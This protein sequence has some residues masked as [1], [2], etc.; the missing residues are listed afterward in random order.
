MNTMKDLPNILIVDDIDVNL[1]LLE[2]IIVN[3][4]TVNLIQALSGAEALEKIKG[5]ELA[6]AILD[7]K[8]PEMNG[9]ELALKIN[10]NRSGDNVPVIFLTAMSSNEH[11]EFIGYGSGAV[12]Y[13]YKPV[14]KHILLSKINVFID[15]YNHKQTIIKEAI[16]LQKTTDE[17]VWTNAALIK[18]EAKYRSYIESA[19]DGVFV[20]DENGNFTEVNN[21][22]C[23]IT[24]YSKERLIKM[25]IADLLTEDFKESGLS[26]YKKLVQVGRLKVD[27]P[28]RN[29]NGTKRWWAIEAIKLSE[30][31]FLGFT[32]DITQRIELENSL[33]A[34]QV[35]LEKQ[36]E[37]IK[38]AKNL[39]EI[40]SRKY[41]ELYDFAPSGYFTLSSEKKIKELNHSGARILGKERSF[42][43][44]SQFDYFISKN[45][46]LEFDDFF[47]NVYTKKNK[48]ACDI[49]IQITD[50][51][52]KNVHIEGLYDAFN[53]QFLLNV[54]DISE[55]KHIEKVLRESEE[56]Y[57]TMLNASP[58]GIFL[59][60]MNGIIRE[61]SD[62]G[63]EMLKVDDKTEIIG[64]N[65]SIFIPPDEINS[66]NKVYENTL[67]D[68]ICQN[69]EVKINKKNNTT[70]L[71]NVS[72][73]LIQDV[74]GKPVS[75][76]IIL[77]D[78]S[79]Q[80]E[81]ETRQIHTD[82]MVSLGQMASGIAHE[83][84]QPLN[85]ISMVMDNLLFNAAKTDT[86]DLEFL[87]NKSDKIFE[88]ITRISN[89]ID[90]VRTF[91]RSNDNYIL[92][93]FDINTS[94]KNACSMLTEQFK[95]QGINLTLTL[96]KRI[97][98]IIGNTYE[99]EQVIINLLVNAK[100][101]LIE[102]KAKQEEHFE[103]KVSIKTWQD[104]Q[105]VIIEIADNGIGIDNEGLSKAMLPFYTTK[106]EGKGTGLGLSI[107]YQIIKEMNGTIDIS[108]ERFVGTKIK[109]ILDTQKK[110]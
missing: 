10:E 6:L 64:N 66:I 11:D 96:D 77:R 107:C 86:I 48:Q 68:G 63:L 34:Y 105:F 70:F 31:R 37:E 20:T 55:L 88:N 81:I 99:L 2:T 101:A 103:L 13:L 100:D 75:F 9:F 16:K 12:D 24:G 95:H 15:L 58:D 53:E 39:A 23:R 45:S 21:A 92:T 4:I 97:P 59:I 73:T 102:K 106:E 28:F 7:V 51:Q 67:H 98:T 65:F 57:R 49:V 22:A 29:K 43:I 17:L 84:N 30:S 109:L 41:S 33:R 76:M 36:N 83:I 35:E 62:I 80:K 42:L 91:S 110:K 90:H 74:D 32:I 87:K 60:D 94:I 72:S 27:L 40:V 52:L 50:N 19:P 8:M 14:R 18:S 71:S 82:R 79:F 56:K 47:R 44:G 1:A 54:I 3:S 85:I 26:Q 89:I 46:L 25:S 104:G 108:S 38:Q 5:I 69:L 93:A 61:V 78:I